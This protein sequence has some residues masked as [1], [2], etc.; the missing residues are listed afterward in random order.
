MFADLFDFF[1]RT[2]AKGLNGA[3]LK[4]VYKSRKRR[5]LSRKGAMKEAWAI[6]KRSRK[7][8]GKK[9]KKG[10][11]KGRKGKKAKKAGKKYRRPRIMPWTYGG[12]GSGFHYV[13]VAGRKRRS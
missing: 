5:G 9:S 4:K 11:K 6:Q 2:M 13:K 3:L 8:R 7:Y 12:V 10:K 1:D